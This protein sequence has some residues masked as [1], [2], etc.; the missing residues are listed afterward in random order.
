MKLIDFIKYHEPVL[1]LDEVKHGL[2]LNALARAGGDRPVELSY[3]T[4]GGPGQCA[5]KMAGHS[6]VLGALDESQCRKL[7][8]LTA[9]S[10]YP[11]VIGPDLTVR[12]FADRAVQLGVAFL[13]P[14]PMQICS[15]TGKPRYP[16]SAGHARTVTAEDAPL[17]A[18]WMS[19]FQREAVPHDPLP[20]PEDLLRVAGEGNSMFWVYDGRPV[21]M[22]G[23]RRRLK[24]SAAIAGVYTPPELRCQGYAGSVT[25]AVVER[26]HS[27][28]R[29]IAYLYTDLRNPASNRCYAKIG[30]SPVCKSM[31]FHRQI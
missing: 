9:H 5:V 11:G 23:I 21:S 26:I 1:A 13:E 7:A 24:N 12:W 31:H 8:E 6:I 2:I 4:I 19:A 28:G 29:N 3:W 17:F 27:E 25:A 16:G 10:E 20:S 30:F 14:E 18:D 15:L 22:A